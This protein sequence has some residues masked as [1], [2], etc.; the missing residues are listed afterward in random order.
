MVLEFPS[1][2]RSISLHRGARGQGMVRALRGRPARHGPP[3]ARRGGRERDP[4]DAR[5]IIPPRLAEPDRRAQPVKVDNDLYVRDYG[6]CILCY[7]CRGVRHRRAEHLRDR[8]GR[9]RLRRARI[10]TEYATPCPIPP[11]SIAATASG[12]CPTGALMFKSEHDLRAAGRW[13]GR[14][15]RSPTPSVPTAGS[16]ARCSSGCRT[17]PSSG[18]LA[19]RPRCDRRAPLHQGAFRVA[20]RGNRAPGPRAGAG[21]SG[22]RSP[23]GRSVTIRTPAILRGAHAR[24]PAGRR[25][26]PPPRARSGR[27]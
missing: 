20:V 22:R 1:P 19:S 18:D 10:S 21:A 11:A 15:R 3:A 9:P 25:D 17:T 26:P 4:G 7:K 27:E 24:R 13:D 8:R 5:V 16:G 12:V 2:R 23:G 6:K 14:A